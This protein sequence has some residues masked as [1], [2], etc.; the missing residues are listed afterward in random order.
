MKTISKNLAIA[1]L[2]SLAVV[3]PFMVLEWVNNRNLAE[4]FPITL[5]GFMWLL[6]IAFFV[7]L[8]PIVQN[9]RKGN[10]FTAKPVSL[11]FRVVF[12][13]LIAVVWGWGLMDQMPCFLGVPN[14]D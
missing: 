13:V 4:S 8:L 6:A 14:C 11:L 7:L 1:A 9:L 10:S 3:L 12:L 2:I 5:F